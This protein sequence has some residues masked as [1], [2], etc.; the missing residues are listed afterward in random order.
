MRAISTWQPFAHLIAIGAKKIE[1]RP[2][3]LP[4]AILGQ[5]IAIAA[6]KNIR[7]A[8]RRAIEDPFL[9]DEL[10][11]LAVPPLDTL[12][13]GCVVATAIAA[14]S[15]PIT[16]ELVDALSPAEFAMGWY[17][18]GRFAWFLE[19]VIK[20]E[21]V[22]ARGMQGFWHWEPPSENPPVKA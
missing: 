15:E 20:I 4:P 10:L 2:Y 12:P 22:P 18:E 16:Q 8:Q 19:D 5:R 1:T 17:A 21:P 13:R 3:P 11:R 7:S 6:T 9:Q 14:R